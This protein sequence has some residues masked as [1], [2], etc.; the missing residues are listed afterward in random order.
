MGNADATVAV[1]DPLDG[2]MGA[3][4]G[5]A[6]DTLTGNFADGSMTGKIALI[7]RGVCL[8]T[9]KTINAQN[10]GAAAVVIYNDERPGL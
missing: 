8:F 1:A 3:A 2:C 4:D 9:S 10:A 5:L 6:A 7:R